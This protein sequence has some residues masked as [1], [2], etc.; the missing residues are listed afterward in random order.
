MES[1]V[2]ANITTATDG[3]GSTSYAYD[4]LNR[5]TKV[6][7]PS[8][9]TINYTYDARGN[10][11]TFTS[12]GLSQSYSDIT[13]TYNVWD[14]LESTTKDGL[15]TDYVYEMQGLRLSK[16]TDASTTR[17]AYNNSGEVIAELSGTNQAITNY[18]WGS[19]S[20]IGE[21]RNSNREELFLLVQWPW[22]CCSDYRSYRSSCE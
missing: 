7:R 12:S 19:G 2:N 1:K 13:S 9:Q 15:T 17:Y 21:E 8:G 4:K 6:T 22:R 5:L 11:S 14:Q 18:I 16:T 10:R 20:F 3:T